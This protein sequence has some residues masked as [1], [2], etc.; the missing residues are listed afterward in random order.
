M[1]W[2]TAFA[3]CELACIEPGSGIV[4][5]VFTIK[6]VHGQVHAG[7]YRIDARL[8]KVLDA[9]ETGDAAA[10][11]AGEVKAGTKPHAFAAPVKQGYLMAF[12]IIEQA[13]NP[14]PLLKTEVARAC[15]CTC[16]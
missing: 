7:D 4:H 6:A 15:L 3:R 2:W 12:S 11:R 13:I 10:G 9:M 1:P 5:R 14:C 16:I 8:K